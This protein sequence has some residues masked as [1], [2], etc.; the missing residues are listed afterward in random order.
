MWIYLSPGMGFM[1]LYACVY[2]GKL[3][4]IKNRTYK[5]GPEPESLDSSP[6]LNRNVS[7]GTH[8]YILV[9]FDIFT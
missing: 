2:M 3:A 4:T 5:S 9:Y 6:D 7:F 8:H 1:S